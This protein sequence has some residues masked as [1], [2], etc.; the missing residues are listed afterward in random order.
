MKT[1]VKIDSTGIRQS[2][3]LKRFQYVI[4]DG[5]REPLNS[6]QI[7]FG[8]ALHLFKETLDKTGDQ[9]KSIFEAQD[10]FK[11]TKYYIPKGKEWM[12]VAYLTNSCLSWLDHDKKNP[13]NHKLLSF[14][15]IAQAERKFAIPLIDEDDLAILLC[16]TIDRIIQFHSQAYAV[17]DWKTSGSWD[18][19]KFFLEYKL[20]PQMLTYCYALQWHAKQVLKDEA[21]NIID[22]P[23]APMIQPGAM[24]G[25]IFL[26]KDKD[27]E[28]VNSD[29]FFYPPAMFDEYLY[30]LHE[31]VKVI[32]EIVRG[33]RKTYRD[34]LFNGVCKTPYGEHGMCPF[35]GVCSMPDE[36]SRQAMLDQYF[37]K[38]PYDPL[39]LKEPTDV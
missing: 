33:Q 21:G 4:L 19:P 39:N 23:Y 15:G 7:V 20:S 12:N 38:R 6:V 9:H 8:Q 26:A 31:L 35:F 11:R 13:P 18:K 10:F 34:G 25:G 14:H 2:A 36:I 1:I 27:P 29:V 30:K 37:I 17:M 24:I 32:A 16:G 22:N 3:C 28:F 5:Y